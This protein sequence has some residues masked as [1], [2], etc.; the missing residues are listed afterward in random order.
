MFFSLLNSYVKRSW[1]TNQWDMSEPNTVTSIAGAESVRET[2]CNKIC[3]GSLGLVWIRLYW[4]NGKSQDFKALKEFILFLEFMDVSHDFIPDERCVDK[5]WWVAI[6]SWAP[7]VDMKLVWSGGGSSVF[8]NNGNMTYVSWGRSP[9]RMLTM[10]QVSPLVGFCERWMFVGWKYNLVDSL[11][12]A[13]FVDDSVLYNDG[14]DI[15]DCMEKNLKMM[16]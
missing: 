7:E 1:A 4:I 15:M 14:G 12:K 6:G 16:R 2:D 13:K 5:T 8:R 10:I 3:W 11:K 9:L